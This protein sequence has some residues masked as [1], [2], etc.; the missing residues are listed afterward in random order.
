MTSLFRSIKIKFSLRMRALTTFILSILLY[1]WTLNQDSRNK[2]A[3]VAE[4]WFSRH[5]PNPNRLM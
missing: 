3:A 4:M 1:G 2:L 5:K